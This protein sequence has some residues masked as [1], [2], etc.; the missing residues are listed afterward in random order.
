[1]AAFYIL[2]LLYSETANTQSLL[3]P[4][5]GSWVLH[6]DTLALPLL[7]ILRRLINKAFWHLEAVV[8]FCMYDVGGGIY[9]LF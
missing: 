1:M 9:V 8:G 4:G 3:A 7:C 6:V 5:S 2:P